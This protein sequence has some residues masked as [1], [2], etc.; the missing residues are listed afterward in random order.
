MALDLSSLAG[1]TGN[2]SALL[3]SPDALMQNLALGAA[4]S[5]VM[6]GLKSSSGKDALDPLGLFHGK[7]PAAN[8]NAVVGATITA[9]AFAALP[10]GTQAQLTAAGVHIL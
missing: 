9:A 7:E 2:L 8:P 4:G 6:A 1:L 3:P 5:V 10:P